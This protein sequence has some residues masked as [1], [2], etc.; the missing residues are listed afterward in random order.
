MISKIQFFVSVRLTNEITDFITVNR[1]K[2]DECL[3]AKYP[4][5]CQINLDG[6]NYG[7]HGTLNAYYFTDANNNMDYPTFEWVS[8]R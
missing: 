7:N 3:Y 5:G 6:S 2:A 4:N 1:L 8:N